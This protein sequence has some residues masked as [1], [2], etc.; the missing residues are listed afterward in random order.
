MLERLLESKAHGNRSFN[1][2]VTSV[3][4]HVALIIIAV[5]ATAQSRSRPT[6]PPK[7][8][9]FPFVAKPAPP[10]RTVLKRPSPSVK[11]DV[12]SRP[13]MVV[14]IDPK[15]SPID[16]APLSPTDPRDFPRG[17]VSVAAGASPVAA[18]DP[19]ATFRA[20]QVE[21]QVAM[22]PGAPLPAYPEALR[23]A[24]VEGKVIA[25]FTVNERGLADADSVRFIRS[26]NALFEASV[27]NV[28][29]RMRFTPAEIGGKKVR[30]LVQ[31]P[32][33]FTLAGR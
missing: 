16:F 5:H 29:R 3:T 30:Q 22:L 25:Q 2:A 8:V 26:D 1:S 10:A 14:R 23:S 12:A 33:V 6:E 13:L 17:G 24:G 18:V 32:F 31:M 4:A 7:V 21:R 11:T 20:D 27:R 15:I 9:V 28:L 19:T